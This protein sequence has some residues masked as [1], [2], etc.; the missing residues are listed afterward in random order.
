MRKNAIILAAGT[1]SRFVPLSQEY[2][3]GLLEVKGEVLVERQIR[4]LKEA[5][6]DDITI[7]VGY[8]ADKFEY[9]TRIFG[10]SIVYNEDFD[11]YNNISSIIRVLDRLDNTYICSSDNYFPKNVFLED[12]HDSYYSALYVQGDTNEYCIEFNDKDEITGVNI[13]GH[14]S[15]YMIGHAYFTSDFSNRLKIILRHEYKKDSTKNEYWEDV[16]LRNIDRLPPM[17]I[18]RY[19]EGEILEFDSLEELRSFD[20]SYLS[21]TRSTLIKELAQRLGCK[22]S[23]LK[24]FKN[25]P[26]EGDALIFSFENGDDEY[27]FNN[28]DGSITSTSITDQNFFNL[29]NLRA[30]LHSIFPK[31]NVD[32][33]VFS[34]VGGMS[35]KNFK[36]SFDGCSYVMRIPGNGSEGMVE[37]SNEEYNTMVAC[38]LGI[39]PPVLYFNPKTGIKITEFIEN[40]ETLGADSIQNQDNMIKVSEIYRK[41]HNSDLRLKNEFNIFREIEKYDD[42]IEKANAKMYKG[43]ETVRPK[44]MALETYLDSLGVELKPCHNDALYEN[45]IKAEDGTIYLIDWEYSG[46]NDPMADFAALF[47]EAGFE[48]DNEDF[49]LNRYYNGDIPMSTREKILCYQVLWDYLWAQWTIIKEAKGDDF[50]S[51]GIDR[52]NRAISNLKLLKDENTRQKD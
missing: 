46:M 13:G 33:A 10:V 34:R 29:D 9:L 37:R 2:P 26:H 39:T 21:D 11:K 38:S 44:V 49:I 52:Y 24:N 47:L 30:Q 25:I 18:K 7:V 19:N 1:S 17:K 43:W 20:K 28:I 6:I 31:G 35:N 42:L 3:K 48:K 12:S 40:A 14:G 5:G 32:S 4:Q 22:E 41:V 45:F 15:W 27:C 23:D 16:Y 51:Y 8:K 50:G 36:V